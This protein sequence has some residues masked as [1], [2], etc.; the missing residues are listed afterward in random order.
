MQIKNRLR[1]ARAWVE[2]TLSPR[3]ASPNLQILNAF[4]FGCR[5]PC[6]PRFCPI[7]K[8][9]CRRARDNV[10]FHWVGPTEDSRDSSRDTLP[11]PPPH[12]LPR[13]HPARASLSGKHSYPRLRVGVGRG[14]RKWSKTRPR[15]ARPPREDAEEGRDQ[16]LA[17]GGSCSRTRSDRDAPNAF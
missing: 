11:P 9:V 3:L 14:R 6:E 2:A 13:R 17:G 8:V 15:S 12:P 4:L 10:S 5:H 16:R 7:R 1:G